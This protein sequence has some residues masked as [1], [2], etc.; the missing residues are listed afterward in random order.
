M[1]Q[2]EE[3]KEEQVQAVEVDA[4]PKTTEENKEENK[5]E[6]NKE[7]GEEVT[8]EEKKDESVESLGESVKELKVTTDAPEPPKSSGFWSF[9]YT[10][11]SSLI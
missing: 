2:Q 4:S 3:K 9:S 5:A 1:E 11:R 6:D 7:K 10:V 8:K